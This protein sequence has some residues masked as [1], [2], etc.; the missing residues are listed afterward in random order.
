VQLVELIGFTFWIEEGKQA[1]RDYR[2]KEQ[3]VVKAV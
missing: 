2:E 1:K 3:D